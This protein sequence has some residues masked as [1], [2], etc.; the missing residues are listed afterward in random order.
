M[1]YRPV[2]EFTTVKLHRLDVRCGALLLVVLGF[3]TLIGLV[4]LEDLARPWHGLVMLLIALALYLHRYPVDI[5]IHRDRQ[6]LRI[7]TRWTDRTFGLEGVTAVR[8]VYNEGSS[9]VYLVKDTGEEEKVFEHYGVGPL[10]RLLA[11]WLGV[12]VKNQLL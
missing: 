9:D 4:R 5:E 10:V 1:S 12:P 6:L 3:G 7:R 11:D 2:Y 8:Y